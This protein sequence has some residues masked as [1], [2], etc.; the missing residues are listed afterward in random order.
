MAQA[1]LVRCLISSTGLPFSQAP[2]RVPQVTVLGTTSDSRRAY[3]QAGGGDGDD[4]CSY[5]AIGPSQAAAEEW[6]LPSERT[7]EVLFL[8]VQ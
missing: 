7:E 2:M 8:F 5:P 1:W 3:W 6:E 4:D